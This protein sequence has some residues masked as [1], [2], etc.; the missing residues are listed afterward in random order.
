[1]EVLEQNAIIR[2]IQSKGMQT[3]AELSEVTGV[4]RFTLTQI[5]RGG[6]RIVRAETAQKLKN[7][8]ASEQHV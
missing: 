3:M 6:R 8:L 2:L 5:M 4:N 1:M 7:Y